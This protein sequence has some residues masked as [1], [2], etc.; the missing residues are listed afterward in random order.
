MKKVL[1]AIWEIF[2]H[3]NNWNYN[4]YRLSCKY[5]FV[6]FLSCLRN[7]KEKSGLNQVGG[8]V[9]RNISSFCLER[10]A[11]YFKL[12]LSLIGLHKRISQH[13]ITA[14]IIVPWSDITM[15]KDLDKMYQYRHRKQ[16]VTTQNFTE[17]A[18]TL[19]V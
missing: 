5:A 16:N 19:I 9:A 7:W 11:L 17:N 1:L 13:D 10:V 12:I 6:P 18:N 15:N 14:R 4:S 2:L 8:L 3:E